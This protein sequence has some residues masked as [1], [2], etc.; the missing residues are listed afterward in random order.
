[1]DLVELKKKD[2]KEQ[3]TSD[4]LNAKK[5][6]YVIIEKYW[7]NFSVFHREEILVSDWHDRLVKE[8]IKDN[9][10]FTYHEFVKVMNDELEFFTKMP[11]YREVLNR[12]LAVRYNDM[13]TYEA[14]PPHKDTELA[15]KYLK[16]IRDKQYALQAIIKES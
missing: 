16:Q 12:I 10:R 9:P 3:S 5:A 15:K 4:L 7:A 14:L 11:C 1:M 6:L 2:N 8:S 13:P